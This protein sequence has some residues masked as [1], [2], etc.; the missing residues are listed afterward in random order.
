[1]KPR[2]RVEVTRLVDTVMGEQEGFGQS[3]TSERKQAAGDERGRDSQDGH[4]HV[5]DAVSGG[6]YWSRQWC[7]NEGAD[8]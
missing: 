5:L 2:V 8:K 1:M 3:V 6:K 7:N 4:L